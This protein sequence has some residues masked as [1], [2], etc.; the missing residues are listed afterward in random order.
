MTLGSWRYYQHEVGVE[1]YYVGRGEEPGIWVGSG[2]ERLGLSGVVEEGQLAR[3][4]DEGCH[5]VSG[6]PLGLAYRHDAKRTVVTGYALSFSPPKSVSLVGAFGEEQAVAEVRAGHDAAV[7][8][9]LRFLEEH[10]AFSRMGRGGPFQVDTEGFVA[11][12]FNHR[13]SRAGDP[14]IH[15]HVLVANKVRCPDGR[16]RALDGRELFAFQKA[17]GM[18]YNATLR[19]ELSRRLGVAWD[20]VDHNGQADIIGV[21]RSLLEHFSKRRKEVETRATV[22]IA[23][24]E[25]KLG[26]TLTDDERAEQF[27]FAAY[28]TRKAKPALADDD[29]SLGGRWRAEADTAGWPAESWLPETLGR[30]VPGRSLEPPAEQVA[31][32]VVAEL[33]EVRSTWNRADVFKAVARRIPY[34]A[35]AD[36]EAGRAWAERTMA[37][38]LAHPGVVT[39]TSPLVAEVPDN[40]RRR[41][42]LPSTERH[43]QPRYTTRETLAREARVLDLVAGGRHAGAAVAAPAAIERAA[44][45]HGLGTDQSAVLRRV[46]HGGERVVCVVG[47]AGS[48]KTRMTGAAAQAWAEDGTP[49]RG[50]AISAVA[51]GVLTQEAGIPAETVAKFLAD[52]RRRGDPTLGLRPAEVVVVDE[53]GMAPT[54]DL[55]ALVDAVTV[56]DAKLVLVGDH[57]QL[58][59]VDAGGLFRLLVADSGAAQLTEVRRFTQVW[60]ANASLRLRNGD[61]SVLDE[62]DL[63]G[64]ITGGTT[65][66]MVDDAFR[67]W[68]AARRTGES[69]V[70][71]APDHALVDA[72]AMRARADR[73]AAGEVEP[74]GIVVGRQTIGTG[75]EIVTTRND[76]RLVTTTGAWVRNGDRWRVDERR[77]DGALVVSHL[78]GR[79]RALLPGGYTA[80]HVALAY[81]VTVHKAEGMTVDRG[82]LVTDAATTGEHLYVG[83][84]RGR[85]ENR[86]CVVTEAATTGH[87]HHQP[88]TPVDVLTDAM[89]RSSAELSAT[90]T[91]RQELERSEDPTTL[92]RL[93][94]QARD[95][96]EAG[97]GPDRRPELRR[98]QRLRSDLPAL[99]D[100]VAAN[101][102][103]VL[104]LSHAAATA[105]RNIADAETRLEALTQRR[106]FRRPNQ[107][108]IDA[109][110][111][112]IHSQERSLARLHHER[113]ERVGQL[114]RSHRRLQD[115]ERAVSRIPEVET[116]VT[117]RGDWILS[118]PVELAWEADLAARLTG[119]TQESTQKTPNQEHDPADLDAEAIL[120]AIDLREIDL[121][122]RRPDTWI[123]RRTTD[124]ALSLRR[125]TDV[126]DIALPPLPGRGLD[127]GPD[128]GL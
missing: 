27:Q 1:D 13:T 76:R 2:A 29:A 34:G 25:A 89:H 22:R 85:H 93:W 80:E 117:H 20:P 35:L 79:G 42:G 96:I 21:P 11:A 88:R 122:P 4:F 40:L 92:R 101:Q 61:D 114:A 69:V 119:R 47:P 127:A 110:T 66:E 104:R 28:D 84:T 105:R 43:G 10:A 58:G 71:V 74:A 126:P 98:L 70:V 45:R 99:R 109:T 112:E 116:A 78:D 95:S 94:E 90:E 82:V 50:L 83:M 17:A 118:H 32:E 91:L 30:V 64:R 8:A 97:A 36:A 121:S 56:A 19:A 39:L 68:Q 111:H 46:C 62:Y 38:V 16:W 125:H 87:G 23:A 57:R 9:A 102:R 86:V 75:D 33:A 120:R 7:R 54:A 65:D 3:L 14:Q 72:L 31:A 37:G 67:A 108:A 63:R 128:L 6:E 24:A 15:A 51:A 41:D 77:P 59:A 115:V 18:L 113:A 107:P 124:Q 103:E 49:V 81:A 52:S 44:E 60:E 73:V 26:R 106:R 100:T 55:A 12:W 53:A 48:G 123:E 5:P